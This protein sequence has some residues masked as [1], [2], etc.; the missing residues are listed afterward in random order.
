MYMHVCHVKHMV[1]TDIHGLVTHIM[2]QF[3]QIRKKDS[4]EE[5]K[6]IINIDNC[7]EQNKN[8]KL[9]F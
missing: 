7:S 2:K 9:H 3:A 1:Y 8:L 6:R 4:R 5:K